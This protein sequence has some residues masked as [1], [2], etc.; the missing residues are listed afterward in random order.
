[1]KWTVEL[2]YFTLRFVDHFEN[3]IS[4]VWV[5]AFWGL[6]VSFEMNA[7]CLLLF[8]SWLYY[9]IRYLLCSIVNSTVDWFIANALCYRLDQDYIF[10]EYIE[11]FRY[12]RRLIRNLSV[13]HSI[14]SLTNYVGSSRTRLIGEK[15]MFPISALSIYTCIYTH[16]L[17]QIVKKANEVFSADVHMWQKVQNLNR[18]ERTTSD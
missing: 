9:F 10:I 6:L 18:T 15:K 13:W 3:C 16:R 8:F 5:Y 14:Y 17:I 4:C 7:S 1:M 12:A 11:H 2:P